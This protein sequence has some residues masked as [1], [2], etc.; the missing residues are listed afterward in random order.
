M[1]REGEEK[2]T[3]LCFT[4]YSFRSHTDLKG[5]KN[6]ISFRHLPIANPPAAVV[7]TTEAAGGI[8]N[9]LFRVK[10]VLKELQTGNDGAGS[11]VSSGLLLLS[12]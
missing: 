2:F 1:W 5:E 10:V 3:K 4:N 11:Y 7:A 12:K 6:Q 8:S 9:K